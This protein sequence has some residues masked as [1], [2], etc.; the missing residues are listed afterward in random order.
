MC[1]CGQE[2]VRAVGGGHR[3]RVRGVTPLGDDVY[4]GVTR[5]RRVG[6]ALD[7]AVFLIFGVDFV[8]F[9]ALSTQTR[10]RAATRIENLFVDLR[11][12]RVRGAPDRV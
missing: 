5:I 11:A 8:D 7:V 12:L 2:Y 6:V 1:A 3:A 10:A 9:L 4:G